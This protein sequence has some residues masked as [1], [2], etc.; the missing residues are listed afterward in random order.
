MRVCGVAQ[1]EVIV[2]NV[3]LHAHPESGVTIRGIKLRSG[4][5]L[6]PT[7]VFS[8]MS[9]KWSPC[10]CPGIILTEE[11]T[12]TWVRPTMEPAIETACVVL[13]ATDQGQHGFASCGKCNHHIEEWLAGA[14]CPA[15][16]VLL[17]GTTVYPGFGGSD[18]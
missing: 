11:V 13:T 7:D 18:F 6:S 1:Q 4:D 10:P 3:Q 16:G 17:K 12:V 5:I 14:H 9:G 2:N 15:C 8:S